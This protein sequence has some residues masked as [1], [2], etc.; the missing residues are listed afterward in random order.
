MT[1]GPSTDDRRAW[2]PQSFGTQ[3]SQRI[4]DP[5]V[6][7]L[8]E[9]DRVL[10]HLEPGSV[11]IID[12]EGEQ[13]DLVPEI[14]AAA[15]EAL[16]AGSAVLDGYL[17]PQ[18]LRPGTGLVGEISVPTATEMTTQLLLGRART[19][20][21][22]LAD[23]KPAPVVPGDELALVVVDLLSLDDEPL[24]DVPLLERKRL[25]E[26]ALR[27]SNLVRL[28]A[29]VRPPIDAWIGSWRSQ[30]FRAIAFKEVNGRY[31]PGERADDW[32][33]A[34]IPTR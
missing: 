9:G 34:N 15:A 22:E 1:A 29:Y 32:A 24:L 19:R 8:W 28:G 33:V 5:L 26:G 2:R 23:A 16:A 10:V 7:P 27:Q 20:K 3:R 14:A 13:V 30:G 4:R 31:R 17:T 6:E 18:P 21:R 11:T 25:L 12:I